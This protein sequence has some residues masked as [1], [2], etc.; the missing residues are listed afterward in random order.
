MIDR[1]APVRVFHQPIQ[2]FAHKIG[3][4]QCGEIP[5]KSRPAGHLFIKPAQKP[6]VRV[7]LK[8]FY[9]SRVRVYSEKAFGPGAS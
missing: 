1:P 5:R 2:R 9:E 3:P 4:G 6:H 7:V 8:P